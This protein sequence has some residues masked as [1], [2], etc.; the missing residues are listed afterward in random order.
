MI[1]IKYLGRIG[2]LAA[3]GASAAILLS[4]CGGSSLNGTLRAAPTASPVAYGVTPTNANSGIGGSI[5]SGLESADATTAYITGALSSTAITIPGEGPFPL[6]FP[7]G[8]ASTA[9]NPDGTS[10]LLTAAPVGASVRFKADLANGNNGESGGAI[11]PA[12]V[13]LTSSDIPGFA[14]QTLMFDGA[15]IATG[16]LANGQYVSAPFPLAVPK[17]GIYRFAVAV[18]DEGGQSS[19]TTFA[20]AA[21]APTDAALFLENIKPGDTV[22]IDG[23]PGI[24]VYPATGYNA[25]TGSASAPTIA[26]GQGTVVLFTTPGVH[27][28]VDASTDAKGVVTTT[29]QTITVAA[30]AVGTTI[31]Q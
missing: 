6:G 13:I 24:G 25:A 21:V 29:T 9:T 20:V 4:G 27:K 10:V 22:T 23:G 11:V 18:A 16:P 2:P 30:T 31:I 5:G 26:D 19:S 28:I 8:A 17:S 15:N 1:N 3:L 12:S 14:Q 7:A